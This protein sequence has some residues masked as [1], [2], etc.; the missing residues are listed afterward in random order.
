[1]IDDLQER[2]G[3]RVSGIGQLYIRHDCEDLVKRL[4]VSA[5]GFALQA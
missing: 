2:L 1:M 3:T 5:P 4:E